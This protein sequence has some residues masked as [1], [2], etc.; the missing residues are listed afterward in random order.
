VHV[1]PAHCTRRY[2]LLAAG[3]EFA[4]EYR[5]PFV[6]GDETAGQCKHGYIA[7]VG[8][9]L[10]DRCALHAEYLVRF[11]LSDR[12]GSERMVDLEERKLLLEV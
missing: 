2:R 12:R 1:A 7:G 5:V 4:P 8:F 9:M 6:L 10:Y 3:D 11:A